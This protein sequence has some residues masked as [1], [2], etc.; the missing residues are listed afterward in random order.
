MHRYSFLS[1]R[2]RIDAFRKHWGNKLERPEMLAWLH[3]RVGVDGR[4]LAYP[5]E[6]Y[7]NLGDF[8]QANDLWI[9]AALELAHPEANK[10]RAG[11]IAAFASENHHSPD[12]EEQAEKMRADLQARG[13]GEIL[14]RVERGITTGA[15]AGTQL[16]GDLSLGAAP[17]VGANRARANT[18][19]VIQ[20]ERF[21]EF[22][23]VASM[24]EFL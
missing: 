14:Q 3:E 2:D 17:A 6:T 10:L 18:D 13:L 15:V 20:C 8:G 23:P 7:E 22:P 9:A 4:Y 24:R 12:A 21:I 16:R 5:V 19:A 11:I 1:P